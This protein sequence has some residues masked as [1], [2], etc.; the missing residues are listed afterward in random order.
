MLKIEVDRSDLEKV[1][2]I[3]RHA[4]DCHLAQD[5]MNSHIHLAEH[6][7]NSPLSSELMSAAE[8]LGNMLFV[9]EEKKS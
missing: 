1:L 2:D 5:V 3:V 7:R 4:R 8:R 9:E 6:P